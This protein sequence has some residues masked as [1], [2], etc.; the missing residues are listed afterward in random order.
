MKQ[1]WVAE[2]DEGMLFLEKSDTFLKVLEFGDVNDGDIDH[3][4]LKLLE[5]LQDT[6]DVYGCG[7][8][9]QT[10]MRSG[11]FYPR[12]WR[13]GRTPSP[14]E[15]SPADTAN[16]VSTVRA[17]RMLYSKL[18]PLFAAV[19]PHEMQD[20]T[21]GLLQREIMILACTEVESAWRTVLEQSNASP[22]SGKPGRWSTNDYV[23]LLGPMR[24]AEWKVSLSAHHAYREIRRF[25]A[26][27]LEVRRRA[28][29][30]TTPTTP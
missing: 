13:G 20:L 2:C 27:T 1:I 9:V 30:G 17:T 29:S 23:R 24:L 4:N 8:A 26:G 18:G 25:L 11:E 21:Y 5:Q 10:P 16:L 12:I 7:P 3:E 14:R 19:E 6:L 28:F 15:L 22:R